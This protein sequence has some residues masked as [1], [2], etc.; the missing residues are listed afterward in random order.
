METCIGEHGGTFHLH[1]EIGKAIGSTA[2][3]LI[4]DFEHFYLIT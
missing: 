2:L 1:L 3:S 4:L